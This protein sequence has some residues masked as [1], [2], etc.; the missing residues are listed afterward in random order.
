[1]SSVL[2]ITHSITGQSWKWRSGDVDARDPGFQPDDLVAQLLLAR[3][4]PRDDLDRHRNPTI[5][6]LS[7]PIRRCS[8]TWTCAAERLADAVLSST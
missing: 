5:R 4:V 8:K 3:G 7:C 6:G 1:M 2:N